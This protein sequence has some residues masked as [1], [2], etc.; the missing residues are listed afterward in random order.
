MIYLTGSTGY[1][2]T[3]VQALLRQ[4]DIPVFCVG[5]RDLA[6]ALP[7]TTTYI[8]RADC[9]IHLAWYA[10]AGDSHPHLHARSLDATRALADAVTRYSRT[11]RIVFA[12]TLSIYGDAPA[13]P[14][15]TPTPACTYTRTKLAAEHVLTPFH[16]TTLRLGSLM[17]LNPHGR[18][19]TD[20][21]VN[22]YATAAWQN[23][24]IEVWNPD[25]HKPIL[26]ILDAAEAIIRAALDPNPSEPIANVCHTSA[27]ALHLANSIADIVY[28]HNPTH[29]LPFR[30]LPARQRRSIPSP[31]VSPHYQSHR[32]L[33]DAV[34]SLRSYRPAPEDRTTPWN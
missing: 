8:Q 18:T 19:R 17:G 22:A 2:G 28:Q 15:S 25:D 12:S 10:C 23:D 29:R 30:I 13:H 11:G 24:P 9:V 32:T 20:L 5:S 3:V 16:T 33:A 34:L 26:H 6:A 31:A 1:L 27:P 21:I 14:D 4:R 7:L